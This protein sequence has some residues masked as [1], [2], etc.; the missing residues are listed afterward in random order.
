M[1]VTRTF[2]QTA[3]LIIL[4]FF[5]SG[6]CQ[7]IIAQNVA[8]TDDDAYTADASAMLDVKSLTKGMLVPRMS[9]AQRNGIASPAAG[10][11]V[12]DQTLLS[13]YYYNGS[14]W[15]NLSTGD[16]WGSNGTNVFLSDPGSRLGVGTT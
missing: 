8:I 7:T 16:I 14:T 11:L 10:L 13:F 4:S 12:F 3:K 1:R 2:S 9:N 15:V 6:M 5:I